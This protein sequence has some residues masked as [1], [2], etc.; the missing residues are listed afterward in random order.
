VLGLKAYATTAR[1]EFFLKKEFSHERKKNKQAL[2]LI[3]LFKITLQYVPQAD[4]ELAM[5]IMLA[6]MRSTCLCFPSTGIKDVPNSL[7]AADY[8]LVGFIWLSSRSLVLV[9]SHQRAWALS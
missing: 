6:W 3:Y 1:Q 9:R 4:L 7:F 5:L 2:M 8:R